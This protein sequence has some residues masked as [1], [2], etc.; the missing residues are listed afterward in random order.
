MAGRE[1]LFLSR[2]SGTE[3]HESTFF[4]KCLRMG[5]QPLV[6][7]NLGKNIGLKT[8]ALTRK[9]AQKITYIYTQMYIKLGPQKVA[10]FFTFPKRVCYFWYVQM[11][12]KI[13]YGQN[14]YKT[15]YQCTKYLKDKISMDEITTRQNIYG[16]SISSTK[17]L[18]IYQ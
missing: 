6:I 13:S 8:W 11:F 2:I 1:F 14:I 12:D 17:Y 16:T 5:D 7:A 15:K 3:R 18:R 10:V 4:Q 9:T